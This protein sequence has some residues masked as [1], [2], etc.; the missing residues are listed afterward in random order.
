MSAG[1]RT[2]SSGS[3]EYSVNEV[4]IHL[5]V[6]KLREFNLFSTLAQLTRSVEGEEIFFPGDGLFWQGPEIILFP[7]GEILRSAIQL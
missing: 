4:F 6:V 7:V 1:F 5:Y 3:I 2:S